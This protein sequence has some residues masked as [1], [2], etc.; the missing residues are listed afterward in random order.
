MGRLTDPVRLVGRARECRHVER[1]LEDARAGHSGVLVLRGEPGIGKTALLE[2]AVGS[3]QGFEVGRANGVETE[4][5]LPFAGLHQLCAPVLDRLARLPD[6]QREAMSTAFGLSAGRPPDRFLVGLALLSLLSEVSRDT[7]LVCIV[8]DAHWLDAA[9]AHALGFVARRL[10]AERICL[11]VGTRHLVEDFSGLP[12]LVVE[13]LSS[14]DARRLLTSAPQ[15]PIDERVRGRIVEE[16]RGNPLALL[17]WYRASTPTDLAAGVSLAPTELVPDRIEESFRLRLGELPTATQRFLLVAAAAPVGDALL[18]SQAGQRLGLAD[19]SSAPAVEAGFIAVGATVRFR[20]PLVRSAA[21]RLLSAADRR[22]AHQALAQATDPHTDADRRAWHL[23][24]AASR[25]DEAVAEELERSASRAQGRGGLA[26]AGA[27]LERATMLTPEG[28][29]R[30]TRALAAAQA[31]VHAGALADAERLLSAALVGPLSELELARADLVRAQLAF[32][33]RRGNEAGPLLLKAAKRLEPIDPALARATYLDAMY[34]AAFAARLATPGTDVRTVARAARAAPR[35]TST[36]TAP[37]LLLEGLATNYTEGYAAGLPVLRRALAAF[38]PATMPADQELRWLSWAYGT[39]FDVW[40]DEQCEVLSQRYLELAQRLG[41]LTELPI[42]LTARAFSHIFA[43]ELGAAALLVDQMQAATDAIG[44]SHTPPYAPMALAALK[45]DEARAS[46]LITATLQN[47]PGHGDGVGISAAE[48]ANA[49]LCNGAGRYQDALAA[50]ERAVK[51][52]RGLGFANLALIELVEATA[53]LGTPDK[54]QDAYGELAEIARASAT[55]WA[56]GVSA[57]A[58][59]LLGNDA[60]AEPLYL[61]A[62]ER[63]GRTRIRSE[64]ARAHLLYGEW[65]RRQN[66]R[67]DARHHLR[68]AY[69]QLSDMGMEAFADRAGRELA[70]TGE[71]VRKRTV[72]TAVDLTPQELQIARLAAEGRTNPEIG[73]QLFISART[74]EYHLRKVF[75]KVAVSSR[76]ELRAKLRESHQLTGT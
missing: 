15:L 28:S 22:D 64:L 41:A 76:K 71:T 4:M 3:G 72:E 56:L 47:A 34:A 50:S 61:E 37:D 9:S 42:A 11:L 16:A 12:E 20:H 60:T 57:R 10:L 8:D 67:V 14:A 38:G 18:I 30:A 62:V 59:A 13:G 52:S 27:F 36:A 35:S 63:L 29:R 74:V 48:W 53:R 31:K 69:D 55:D 43:G 54:A 44:S 26:A 32:A 23:A 66:R 70:A 2:Y 65:L 17:E 39:A 58:G 1:L 5:E 24:L 75:T 6:P 51:D 21:Y 49:V 46:L 45:G 40:D 7:P 25:P 19:E 73:A 33:G 68:A